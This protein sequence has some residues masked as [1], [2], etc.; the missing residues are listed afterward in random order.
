MNYP[1]DYLITIHI[2][3]NQK[4]SMERQEAIQKISTIVGQDLRKLAEKY[5]VTVFKGD[6]INKGWAG[7]VLERYLGLPINSSQSPNFGSWELKII[8][9]KFL[10]SGK[11][12][13]KET[14]SVTMIDP[15]N[16][17]QTEFANSHLLIKL[18]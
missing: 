7:H 3:N 13:V 8:P 6:K 16:V 10:K 14:M 12:T 18:L 15:Y 1:I 9:L 4:Y 5:E 11:L 2:T 17:A